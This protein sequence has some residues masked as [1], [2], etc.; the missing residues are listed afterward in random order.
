MAGEQHVKQGLKL[1]EKG[2]LQGAVSQF[3]RAQVTDPSNMTADQELKKTL[4]M[5][6]EK[7][8][9]SEATEEAPLM[10]NGQPAM[11]SAPPELKP[12]SRAPVNLTMTNDV[13]VVYDTIG[14]LAGLTVIYDPD[15][16]AK[17]IHV[18]LNNLTLE[19]ALEITS[20][21]S[22]RFGSR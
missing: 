19:Q 7:L 14:K 3:Q 9:S 6:S 17:R 18:E 20:L 8:R 5:I 4:E 12:L 2:D 21:E 10:E 11:A 1:R 22:K 13:K 15:L 16:Q